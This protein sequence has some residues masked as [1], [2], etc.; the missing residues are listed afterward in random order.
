[1]QY[2]SINFS[3]G[4]IFPSQRIS[5]EDEVRIQIRAVVRMAAIVPIGMDF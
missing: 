5:T 1:M 4:E 2:V 3:F